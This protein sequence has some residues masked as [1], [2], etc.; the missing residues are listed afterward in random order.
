MPPTT[1]YSDPEG[2]STSASHRGRHHRNLEP[3]WTIFPHDIH[4]PLPTKPGAVAVL[5]EPRDASDI[6]S[7]YDAASLRANEAIDRSVKTLDVM[8]SLLQE[9][10]QA[11][12]ESENTN[13][14]STPMARYVSS[15]TV[16]L[17]AQVELS[18]IAC[19]RWAPLLSR[20]SVLDWVGT[21]ILAQ[22]SVSDVRSMVHLGHEEAETSGLMGGMLLELQMIFR[23]HYVHHELLL[24][25]EKLFEEGLGEVAVVQAHLANAE[26]MVQWFRRY[27]RMR[28][29]HEG[30]FVHSQLLVRE[31]KLNGVLKTLQPVI[32]AFEMWGENPRSAPL[33][34]VRTHL[35]AVSALLAIHSEYPDRFVAEGLVVW[36]DELKRVVDA[37][38]GRPRRQEDWRS[39]VRRFLTFYF[40]PCGAQNAHTLRSAL[41]EADALISRVEQRL[42]SAGVRFDPR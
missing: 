8:T 42:K 34:A 4:V 19:A 29:F 22:N 7:A 28:A 16:S 6:E 26:E 39:T 12:L 38:G 20:Q 18:L 23:M 21:I 15:L 14:L 37:L 25:V 24:S 30:T 11:L 35:Q 40:R 2:P 10:F 9:G 36:L 27:Q 13:L 31:R 17:E 33:R 32:S 3:L 41:L 5:E 1:F